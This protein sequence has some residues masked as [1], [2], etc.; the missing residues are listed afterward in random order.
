IAILTQTPAA[1]SGKWEPLLERARDSFQLA[2]GSP[3]ATPPAQSFCD[4][5]ACIAN[6][7]NGTGTIVQCADGMWSHSGGRPGACSYHGGEAGSGGS[8][9]SGS[10]GS[11]SRGVGNGYAVTCNDGTTSYSGGIQGACSHH[12]G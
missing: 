6:F 10:S 11:S 4:T 3:P 12:G 2:G 1:E 7:D 9:S 5:H 8:D